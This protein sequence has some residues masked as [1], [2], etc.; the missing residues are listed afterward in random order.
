G[1]IPFL[2][3]TN[4][5][6]K[7]SRGD[8][9]VHLKTAIKNGF[10]ISVVDAPIVIAD[11]LQ[12]KDYV[13]IK[14]HEKHFREVNLAS[15][16][17]QADAVIVLSHFKGHCL[18]GFGGCLKNIS[19]GF[20]SRSGKQMMHSDV[21]PQIN[22]EECSGCARCIGW[23]PADAI[24]LKEGK[25]NKIAV[26]DYEKCFGCG[27]CRVTCREGAIGISWEGESHI[28]Q[29]KIAEYAKAVVKKKEGK[30]GF[31]NYLINITPDCDC[32]EYSDAPIVND[33]GILASLDP[34]AIDK[35]SLD[36]VNKAK[37]IEDSVLNSSDVQRK[38]HHIYPGVNEEKQ[39]E[40]AEEIGLG[41]QDYNLIKV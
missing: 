22:I 30:I 7:G 13:K 12:S 17:I 23:C 4:T 15:G 10:D 20:A 14:V 21:L 27:E 26:I 2:T 35:A 5:L 9:V 33:I 24:T 16:L 19:M 11:G 31:F 6:Y 29:E 25:S 36:L 18:V 41:K 40:Y 34:V 8:A 32:W 38:F 1:G 28:I 3:D 39:L 37:G